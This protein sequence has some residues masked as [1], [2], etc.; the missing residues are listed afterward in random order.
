VEGTA[1]TT[2]RCWLVLAAAPLLAGLHT[3][4]VQWSKGKTLTI[5]CH[6]QWRSA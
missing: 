1:A 5:C 3:L 2:L 6:F 4:K